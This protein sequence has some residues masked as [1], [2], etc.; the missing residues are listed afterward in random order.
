MGRTIKDILYDQTMPAGTH[1]F[2]WDGADNFGNRVASSL[3]FYRVEVN[4]FMEIKKL[5]FL[6]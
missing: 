2:S 4:E 3:Y 5:M 1:R 6:K